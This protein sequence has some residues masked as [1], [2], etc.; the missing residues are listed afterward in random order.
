MARAGLSKNRKFMRLARGLN[1]VA[2]GMGEIMARGV[3]ETL[4]SAAYERADDH[5]GDAD[6]VEIA[7]GWRGE[8]G[9]LTALLLDAAGGESGF[10]EVDPDRGGYRVHDL[11]DHA[12][13]WVKQKAAREA[14]REAAGKTLSDVRRDAR[15][16]ARPV[17]TQEQVDQL[18]TTAQEPV[19]RL[20]AN[21]VPWDGTGR[22]GLLDTPRARVR[23]P[24]TLGTAWAEATG[25]LTADGLADLGEVLDAHAEAAKLAPADLLKRAVVEFE[26]FRAT[27]TAP[28]IP[29]L[30]PRKVR[31][32]WPRLWEAIQGKKPAASTKRRDEDPFAA[33]RADADRRARASPPRPASDPQPVASVLAEVFAAVK[34]A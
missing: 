27:C 6:D 34:G 20:S 31:E 17:A 7:A 2:S 26:K 28:K 29:P 30:S 22:D 13:P 25:Q 24:G 15:K 14:A 11:W 12:P 10:V 19:E 5:L 32:H 18:Q 4:W 33:V 8:R 23:D 3:L 9:A 16:K 21:L 1:H